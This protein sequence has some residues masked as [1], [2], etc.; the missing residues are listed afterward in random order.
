M[1]LER[2][3]CINAE[4]DGKVVTGVFGWILSWSYN[5]TFVSTLFWQSIP[6]LT[7]L[8]DDN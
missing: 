5:S 2:N 4:W 7:G 8:S 6:V 1:R 3:S